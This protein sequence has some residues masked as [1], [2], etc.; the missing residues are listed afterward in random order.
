MVF[1]TGTSIQVENGTFTWDSEAP[2][3]SFNNKVDM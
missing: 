3:A 1:Y 2:P